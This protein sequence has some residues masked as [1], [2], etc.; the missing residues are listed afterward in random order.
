MFRCGKRYPP[1]ACAVVSPTSAWSWSVR[2]LCVC[3]CSNTTVFVTCAHDEAVQTTSSLPR[4]RNR[5]NS[6][7]SSRCHG[8][9]VVAF[10]CMFAPPGWSVAL[11]ATPRGDLANCTGEARLDPYV[12]CIFTGCCR[13]S[14]GGLLG[15]VAIFCGR[16]AARFGSRRCVD[17]GC[18][19]AFLQYVLSCTA[20]LVGI[21]WV[22]AGSAETRTSWGVFS[23]CLVQMSSARAESSGA[24]SHPLVQ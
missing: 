14:S 3:M 7:I 20:T 21:L 22:I 24:Q 5:E 11:F 17:G 2:C 6:T 12:S 16:N 18:Y 13:Y 8:R 10:G 9:T 15:Q 1:R 23:P 4:F 19:S